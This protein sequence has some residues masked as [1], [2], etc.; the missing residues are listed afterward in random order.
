MTVEEY[1]ELRKLVLRLR[2]Y[3]RKAE[4]STKQARWLEYRE[5]AKG[6]AAAF[7]LAATKLE[8]LLQ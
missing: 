6:R 5:R 2:Q 8:A 7:R 4:Q 3:E 1:D